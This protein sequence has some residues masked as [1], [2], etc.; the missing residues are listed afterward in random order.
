[1]EFL[2]ANLIIRF[3]TEDN[4]DHSAR[5][6]SL[7]Q[8]LEVGA[9]EV[10]TCEGVVAEVVYVLGSRSLYSLSREEIRDKL[11]I[12]LGLRGLKL[13]HKRTYVRALD[14]YAA[15]SRLDFV[16]ALAVA[17][18]ERAKI[19]TIVSFDRDFDHVPGIARREPPAR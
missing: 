2:D 10:T 19:G 1:M 9:A 16:D 18:M 11:A 12:I 7:F 13:S 6:R 8:Q 5:A 3:L 4:F 17:H 15:I 14:L